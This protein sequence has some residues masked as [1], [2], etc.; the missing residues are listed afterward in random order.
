M[1]AP[2]HIV[3]LCGSLRQHSYNGM[4]MHTA[5]QALG[6]AVQHEV[7]AWADVPPFNADVLDAQ[8]VPSSVQR[9]RERLRAADGVLLVTPE[10]NYALPGMLKNTLDWLSRG[11]DQPFAGKPVALLSA[12]TGPLGGARVQNEARRVMLFLNALVLQKP[13]VYVGMA[14]SKFDDQGRCTDEATRGFVQAQMAAFQRWI[15]DVQRM[16]GGG[17]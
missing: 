9:L 3:A 14:A 6:P 1:S 17:R 15:G 7:L 10:Y 12:T 2:L 4:L 16:H 8:G 11:A 5:L 13:E